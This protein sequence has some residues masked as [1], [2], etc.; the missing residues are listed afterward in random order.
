MTDGQWEDLL[1][2]IGGD[3]FDPLPVGFLVDGPWIAGINGIGLM[4]YFTDN[5]RW[6]ISAGG[7]TPGGFGEEKIEA[8]CQT[9]AA[10]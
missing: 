4:D 2:I 7:C 9:V 1:S 10:A 6:I 8:F 3:V 5:R